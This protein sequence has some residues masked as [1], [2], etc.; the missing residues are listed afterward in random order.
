MPGKYDDII[1]LPRPRS[2]GHDPM[3]TWQRAA[4]FAAFAALSGF[5]DVIEQAGKETAGEAEAGETWPG[6]TETGETETRE[7]GEEA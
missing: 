1:D 4:P 6:D 5:E 7:T 2:P 3:P